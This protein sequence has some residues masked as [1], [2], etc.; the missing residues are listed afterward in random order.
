[1]PMNKYSSDPKQKKVEVLKEE[2]AAK[3]VKEAAARKDSDK[4]EGEEG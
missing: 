4:K 2:E 3:K 1:M